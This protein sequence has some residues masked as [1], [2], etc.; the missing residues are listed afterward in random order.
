LRRRL[1]NIEAK[2]QRETIQRDA[3]IVEHL[4]QPTPN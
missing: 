1:F 2:P 3:F 4:S